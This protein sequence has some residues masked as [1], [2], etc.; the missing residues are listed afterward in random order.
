MKTLTVHVLFVSMYLAAI[1]VPL[2]AAD[3]VNLQVVK[4]WTA[5]EN[6][7]PDAD[8]RMAQRQ[9]SN[10]A[11]DSRA[12]ALLKASER[13][14]Q[15]IFN[16]PTLQFQKA[17]T[18]QKE[19]SDEMLVEW[20][21]NEPIGKGTLILR[22]TPFMSQYMTQFDGCACHSKEDL[23]RLLTRLVSWAKPPINVGGIDIRVQ[24]SYPAAGAFSGAPPPPFTEVAVIRDFN[25]SGWLRDQDMFLNVNVGKSFTKS[26]YPVA[27]FIPERFPPLS[28]LVGSWSSRHI[29]DEVGRPA[30]PN[31]D[32]DLSERRDALLITEL[33][34]RG[35]SQEEYIELLRNVPPGR[36]YTRAQVVF[37][38]LEDAGKGGDVMR[39]FEPALQTYERVGAPASKAAGELF[40]QLIRGKTCSSGFEADALRLLKEGAFYDSA[41]MYLG[42][43][44]RSIE[45]MRAIEKATVPDGLASLQQMALRDIRNRVGRDQ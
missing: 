5:A 4:D 2:S 39:Y 15:T 21:F 20:S 33:A 43:C 38:S 35:L 37:Q 3:R 9:L 1:G 25:F 12:E 27:P 41:V 42:Q 24:T 31:A 28:E 23:A 11:F 30:G 29:W 8:L 19:N 7:G 14:T 17:I 10:G 18:Y 36:L 40:R 13:F 16:F 32:I 22:D 44:S 6:S 26:Y 34:R 45:S